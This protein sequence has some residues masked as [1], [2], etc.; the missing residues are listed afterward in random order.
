MCNISRP[1]VWFDIMN[2]QAWLKNNAKIAADPELTATLTNS[3]FERVIDMLE[4]NTGFSDP[5]PMVSS[6]CSYME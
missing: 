2:V 3:M 4:K 1:N 5:I 6:G